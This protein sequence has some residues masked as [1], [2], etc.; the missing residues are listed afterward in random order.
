MSP[1]RME[2]IILAIF[3]CQQNVWL[4]WCMSSNALFGT[5]PPETRCFQNFFIPGILIN[6]W[7]KTACLQQLIR[8]ISGTFKHIIR[9][10]LVQSVSPTHNLGSQVQSQQS[11]LPASTLMQDS[12]GMTDYHFVQNSFCTSE[13]QLGLCVGE[14][15]CT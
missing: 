14:T 12:L 8:N 11:S 4:G 2:Y 1:T 3:S 13:V 10:T 6:I 5:Q 7:W 15:D 9:Q